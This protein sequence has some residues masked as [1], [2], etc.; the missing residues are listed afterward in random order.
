MNTEME[1][2]LAML[3]RAMSKELQDSI[4]EDKSIKEIQNLIDEKAEI[5]SKL[6]RLTGKQW[7]DME[8]CTSLLQRLTQIK[9]IDEM[10]AQ[11]EI[12]QCIKYLIQENEMMMLGAVYSNVGGAYEEIQ[13]NSGTSEYNEIIYQYYCWGVEA[14]APAREAGSCAGSRSG[15]Q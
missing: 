11:E 12:E 1:Q 13:K 10:P 15:A 4:H 6:N 8:K 7:D 2:A 5:V 9:S 14:T 3:E